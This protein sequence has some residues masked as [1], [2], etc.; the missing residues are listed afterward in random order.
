MSNEVANKTGQVIPKSLDELEAQRRESVLEN[1]VCLVDCSG[2]MAD[3]IKN[4]QKLKICAA[5]EALQTLW[6]KTDWNICDFHVFQFDD[7]PIAL[8]CSETDPPQIS[9]P[10]DGTNFSSAL[11]AALDK[12]PTR[13]ILCSDGESS[14]PEKQVLACQEKA[15]PVDTIFIQGASSYGIESGETLLRRISDETGGQFTTVDNAEDLATV[16]AQLETSERLLLTDQ[17]SDDPIEL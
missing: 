1:L 4:G 10:Q 7:S 8:S 6:E 5:R 11:Q 12:E 9:D 13:I 15:I 17:S 16:F 2:S 3:Y 14:Y